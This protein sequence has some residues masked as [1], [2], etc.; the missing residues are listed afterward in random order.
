MPCAPTATSWCSGSTGA[1]GDVMV[2]QLDGHG[3]WE[4]AASVSITEILQRPW[5]PYSAY[6]LTES[7]DDDAEVGNR[8]EQERTGAIAAVAANRFQMP[9][10]DV[11]LLPFQGAEVVL[12]AGGR[13]V[14]AFDAVTSWSHRTIR[15]PHRNLLSGFSVARIRS[16]E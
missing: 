2:F 7:D 10:D 15:R 1:H 11:R 9:G 3:G 5:P 14:V 4:A 16:R 6:E 12:L 8:A 13:R